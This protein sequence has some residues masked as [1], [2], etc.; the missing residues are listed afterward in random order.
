MPDDRRPADRDELE[1]IIER[2]ARRPGRLTPEDAA[3]S[4]VRRLPQNREARFRWLR[5]TA[6]AA[7]LILAVGA[8]TWMNL[9]RSA[10]PPPRVGTVIEA[11]VMG[12]DVV[13]SWIDA[14]TPVYFVLG[15]GSEDRGDDR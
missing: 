13:V 15:A 10:E 7:S 6:L 4:V 8:A 2:A 5:P 12:T 11:P 9:R 14:D 1:A 3:Q